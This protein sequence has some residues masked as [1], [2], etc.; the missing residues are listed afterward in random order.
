MERRGDWDEVS[1]L[2]AISWELG[3]CFLEDSRAKYPVHWIFW[4]RDLVR[5]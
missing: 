1:D 2:S 3:T 5:D 4:F